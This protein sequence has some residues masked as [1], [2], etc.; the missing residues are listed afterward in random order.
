MFDLDNDLFD[1]V[2]IDNCIQKLQN[3]SY[4]FQEIKRILKQDCQLVISV[5][6]YRL[7]EKCSWPSRFNDL[8]KHTFSLTLNRAVISRDN[9][10]HIEENLIPELKKL[11]YDSF[12]SFLN[13]NNFDY[14]K[15]VLVDQTKEGAS[16]YIVVNCV[17][18]KEI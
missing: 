11:G 1:Y 14:D 8:H 13:D 9:H 15:P 4:F 12:S 17:N 3:F 5:P 6:D 18:K 10:W 7:Y 2:V 16:C